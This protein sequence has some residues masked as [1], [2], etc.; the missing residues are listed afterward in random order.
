[1]CNSAVQAG[2]LSVALSGAGPSVAAY[3]TGLEDQV[4]NAMVDSF[5][6]N[7]LKAEAKILE[8]DSA[9]ATVS[10]HMQDSY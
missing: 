7:G 6:E 4:A 2:A 3:C 1:M 10:L 5:T 8:I 9:G